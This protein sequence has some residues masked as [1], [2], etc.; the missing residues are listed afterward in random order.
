[1]K[2]N[3]IMG[4]IILQKILTNKTK[5]NMIRK[6]YDT[7]D[8]AKQCKKMACKFY[9]WFTGK[10]TFTEVEKCLLSV[11]VNEDVLSQTYNYW[12]S[13]I[14]TPDKEMFSAS[15]P[16][17]VSDEAEEVYVWVKASERLPEGKGYIPCKFMGESCTY[18][19]SEND[20]VQSDG[21]TVDK[22]DHNYIEWLSIHP[23]QPAGNDAVRLIK[24]L[25]MFCEDDGSVVEGFRTKEII[26][27]MKI[28]TT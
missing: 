28:L 19:Y 16:A 8:E 5:H 14:F 4:N 20:F 13:N 15:Q 21:F 3:K 18:Y 25:L 7:D 26:S 11:N 22:S 27:E 1:M 6:F 17:A 23:S 24:E 10:E 2:L 12:V 9:L